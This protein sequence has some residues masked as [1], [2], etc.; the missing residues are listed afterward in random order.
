MSNSPSRRTA[1]S[2]RRAAWPLPALLV[3]IAACDS[4]VPTAPTGIPG[5][6][7][8][9]RN[10]AGPV[11]TAWYPHGDG[12]ASRYLGDSLILHPD[13]TGRVVTLM[14]FTEPDVPE[15]YLKRHVEQLRYRVDESRRITF[16]IRGFTED[17]LSWGRGWSGEAAG[18]YIIVGEV[19]YEYRGLPPAP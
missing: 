5:M 11:P 7:V 14:E 17:G 6:Y 16:S 1:R 15:P 9:V 13:F 4:G 8:E 19:A 3:A 18:N 12:R 10:Q 2:A